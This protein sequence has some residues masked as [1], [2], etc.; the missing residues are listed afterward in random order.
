MVP[1]IGLLEQIVSGERAGSAS[2]NP[3]R[4]CKEVQYERQIGI[5]SGR[6][7]PSGLGMY[8]RLTGWGL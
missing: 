1:A 6:R 5:P 2:I 4:R 8:T 3:Q 7:R